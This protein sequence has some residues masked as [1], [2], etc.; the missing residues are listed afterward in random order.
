VRRQTLIGI[1]IHL[2]EIQLIEWHCCMFLKNN[3]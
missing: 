2:L 3:I 1:P